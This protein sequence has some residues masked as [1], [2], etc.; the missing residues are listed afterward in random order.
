MIASPQAS[1]ATLRARIIQ[2][3]A[4]ANDASEADLAVLEKL[5]SHQQALTLEEGASRWSSLRKEMVF[6]LMKPLGG[7]LMT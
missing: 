2:R 6:A 1:L 5:R 3:Q 4:T 7:G